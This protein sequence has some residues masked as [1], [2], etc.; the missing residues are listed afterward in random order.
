MQTK[1][2]KKCKKEKPLTDFYKDKT[3][4][5]GVR[6]IC[7]DC[8]EV[9]SIEKLNKLEGKK[10]CTKCKQEKDVSLFGQFKRN[11]DRL[12]H[13]CLACT[14]G[15][16]DEDRGTK[17]GKHKLL[18]EGF[19]QCHTC[20]GVKLLSDFSL[21]NRS[22]DTHY[23]ECR[24]CNSK[25]PKEKRELKTKRKELFLQGKNICY[26]CGEIKELKD[27]PTSKSWNGVENICR[28]CSHKEEKEMR[29][30]PEYRERQKNKPKR[31]K[32]KEAKEKARIRQK[33]N[34]KEASAKEKEKLH[35]DA[36]F[37]L[38]KYLRRDLNLA[39]KRQGVQKCEKTLELLGCSVE[40]FFDYMEE[41]FTEGMSW[42][43]HSF[44]GWH[45]D[46][47]IPMEAFDLK[48]PLHRRAC[49]YYTNLQP[50]WSTLNLHKSDSYNQEDFDIHLTKFM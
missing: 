44:Y 48:Q 3:C 28:V 4:R 37:K 14:N 5:Y 17:K 22:K 11:K 40:F 15:G 1:T 8:H 7:K 24:D 12:S 31:I 30:S 38:K 34:R 21:C 6:A 42:E 29:K 50:L 41:K 47:I 32:S 25:S 19:K 35:T 46:H 33:L 10:F 9:V 36:K 45:I 16:T 43:N 26:R 18:K 49:C 20:K 39:L 27:F 2:C 23:Y 13:Y